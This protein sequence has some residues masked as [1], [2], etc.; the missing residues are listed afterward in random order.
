MLY[1]NLISDK[2]NLR[3][4]KMQFLNDDLI[5]SVK[6]AIRTNLTLHEKLIAPLLNCELTVI[7][8][9]IWKA[10]FNFSNST[11]T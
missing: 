7:N 6:T 11:E 5:Y 2:D 4:Y 10:E 9:I 3:K 1:Y 8:H